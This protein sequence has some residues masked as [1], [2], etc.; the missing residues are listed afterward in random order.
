MQQHG[1]ITLM[2]KYKMPR[3]GCPEKISKIIN[4]RGLSE[5]LRLLI[6]TADRS[7]ADRL[8]C[9]LASIPCLREFPKLA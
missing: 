8:R 3:I 7:A 4:F 2:V 1:I 6:N 9:L 5:A